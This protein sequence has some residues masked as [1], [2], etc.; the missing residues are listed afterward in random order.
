MP[1]Y[2]KRDD[3]SDVLY[4]PYFVDDDGHHALMLPTHQ[5]PK[6]PELRRILDII[7]KNAPSP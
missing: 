4:D 2:W 6:D 1:A 3:D 5:P 7:A